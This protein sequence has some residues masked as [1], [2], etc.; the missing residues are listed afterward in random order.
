MHRFQR[1]A[2]LDATPYA[3]PEESDRSGPPLT[4]G[5]LFT[6]ISTVAAPH[7]SPE[8][9]R[10]LARIDPDAW[11]HGQ[12]LETILNRFEDED[13]TLPEKVGRNIYF[14]WRSQLD[15]RGLRTGGAVLEALPSLWLA[16]TRGDGG[17]WRAAVGPNRAH[18]EAEQPYNCQFEAGGVRG[19]LEAYGASNIRLTHTPCM[20]DRAPFCVMDVKWDDRP[21]FSAAP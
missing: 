19:L 10:I 16:A 7:C 18:L 13:P 5:F 15:A 21:S 2:P 6:M 11:Y 20:R 12:L 1:Y 14:M 3:P 9:A 17:V 8:I 4:Q